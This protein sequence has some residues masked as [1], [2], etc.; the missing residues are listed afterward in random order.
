MTSAL[1][2]QPVARTGLTGTRRQP[3]V[4][5]LAGSATHTN[6]RLVET[7]WRAGV[8]ARFLRPA[9]AGEWLTAGDVV[10]ARLDVLPTLDGVEP[11][12]AVLDRLAARGV[13]VLNSP[14]A[15][16]AAHDK[17]VTARVLAWHGV[18]HPRTYHVRPGQ[19]L[20]RSLAPV[21]L[22]PRYGT[23]GRETHLCRSRAEATDRLHR[24]AN[25]G[26]FR[27]HGVIMQEFVPGDGQDLRV[28]VAGGRVAGAVARVAAPGEWRTSVARGATRRPV[29]PPQ[30]AGALAV[31]AARAVGG[32]IVGV[33]LMPL[34]A[35]RYLVLEVNAAV[36]FTEEYALGRTDVFE[37]M[38]R[39]MRSLAA[40]PTYV[41]GR[42]VVGLTEVDAAGG[43]AL[44]AVRAAQR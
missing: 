43:R 44:R 36:E 40:E 15:L 28:L 35:G 11:G 41:S 21:V 27:R 33:D 2:P 39:P 31:A 37:R 13:R 42:G 6:R 3:V 16:L 8:P 18:P 17:A 9:E 38:T 23:G 30:R 1:R 24:I 29:M 7:C 20:P 4:A 25:T 26:W 32:R 19:A 34:A 12:L 22:K 5:V 14:S 10:L